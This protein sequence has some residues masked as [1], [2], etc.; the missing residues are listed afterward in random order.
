VTRLSRDFF[1]RPTLAVARALLGQRLVRLYRGRRLA[2]LITEVEAYIGERDLACHARAGRTPRTQIMYGP[3]GTAYLYFNYGMHWMLN[4]VTEAE[5][6]PAAVLIRA[7]EPTEGMTLMQRWR[8]RA[9]ALTDGPAKL[10]QAFGLD[11]RYNGI[12]LTAPASDLFFEPAL[13]LPS[14]RILTAP[15]IGIPNTP[16][17]WLSKKWN[18]RLVSKL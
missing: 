4:V 16:E 7:V 5:G 6:F 17:P 11:R 1:H 3:P 12:D 13:P 18:F 10:T 14:S 9:I 15:R 2:G 8:G